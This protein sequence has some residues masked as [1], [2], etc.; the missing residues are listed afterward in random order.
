[1]MATNGSPG[2]MT[3]QETEGA[4][5]PYRVLDLT[6]AKG[7][8]CGKM[9]ADLG[10]D[11]I[12]VE[13]PS[14]DPGRNLGPFYNDEPHPEG[15]L[16]WWAYNTS[17]RG[18]TLDLATKEGHEA[19]L[20]LAKKSDFVIESFTPGHMAE[21]GLSYEE[22]AKAN[23]GIIM[24][25]ISGFGQDGPYAQY[26][27]PDIV[28]AAISGYMNLSGD[29]DR[30]PL[31][32]TVPQA[33]LNAANDAAAG[34]MIAL[35]YRELTGEGQWVD[36]SAQDCMAWH[37]FN[38]Y[39]SWDFQGINRSRGWPLGG[40]LAGRVIS[41]LRLRVFPCRDGYVHFLP[42]RGRD[43]RRTR[44]LVDWMEEEGMANDLLREVDWETNPLVADLSEEEVEQL[45]EKALERT[46]S[47]EPFLLAKTKKELFEQAVTRGLLL[48]PVNSTRDVSEDV[49]LQARGFWQV[50]DHQE[51]G[52]KV[53]YPGAPYIAEANPYWIRRRAPLIGEHNDEIL[54]GRLESTRDQTTTDERE[55]GDSTEAFKGLKIVDFSWATV[56]PRAVR[57]FADHG[58]TVVKVESPDFFDMVR[59]NPPYKDNMQNVDRS[60]LFAI[61]NVNKYGTTLDLNKVEGLA[62]AKRLIEW[63]DILVESF[64]P[65]IMKRWGL[66]YDSIKDLNP[67]LIYAS[68]S[69]LGQTGPYHLYAGYGELAA[70]IAGLENLVGWPD[71]M[72]CG[73]FWSYTD[74]VAPQFLVTAIVVALLQRR[75]TGKGQYIDQSQNESGLQ[76]LAPALLNYAV[77]GR[78]ATRDG[79][80][81]PYAAPHGAYR[82]TGE[83]RWCV[84]AVHTDEEWQAFCR[85]IGQPELIRDKRFATLKQRKENEAELDRVVEEWTSKLPPE[86]VMER[87][88]QAGV[89]AGIVET[90]EDMHHDP[91][92]KH[93][94]HF[95]LFDHPVIGPHPVDTLPL[96]LSKSPA[97]QYLTSP[98]LGEHNAYVCT[99]I[100]GMSDEEFTRLFQAGVFG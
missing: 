24:V 65:G 7:F 10:A 63:A 28:C 25:S 54:Q 52:D 23:P 93:R 16:L 38:N 14:G 95:L 15:S 78:I 43:G 17:K 73:L 40:L 34:S 82:C 97:R 5:S 27:T 9:I 94:N 53:T 76:F 60:G 1:M 61:Y 45:I 33:Y 67:G 90:A 13:R 71:R 91:Q 69:M 47:F 11:V 41:A 74:H 2:L 64:R 49:H 4:L 81:D 36:V 6:D 56:G 62:V 35:W 29:P 66:D 26:M 96:E 55:D 18:V 80:R 59:L 8:L 100:L 39:V 88:Q 92:F 57:Y 31:R 44:R 46:R 99:E 30:P 3:G 79:N 50:I 51:V 21:L 58:A 83:D 19:F 72:P 75:R 70:A 32:I 77:N 22:L 68:T 42:S 12:K 20:D 87:L 85:V 48:A 84:I 98:C 89:A 86:T 37:C